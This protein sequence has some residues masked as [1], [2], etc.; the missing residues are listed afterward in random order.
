MWYGKLL[1]Y[2]VKH[3]P[4]FNVCYDGFMNLIINLK[5]SKNT[6][7]CTLWRRIFLLIFINAFF[8]WFERKC[9]ITSWWINSFIDICLTKVTHLIPQVYVC[10][11]NRKVTSVVCAY[12]CVFLWF[13]LRKSYWL[14][15]DGHF[16]F[17]LTPYL[18]VVKMYLNMN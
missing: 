12:V 2:T 7:H 18:L 8:Y 1:S 9:S 15:V 5:I 13:F 14:S 11:T 10:I 3:A 16:S 17:L 6:S 4:F